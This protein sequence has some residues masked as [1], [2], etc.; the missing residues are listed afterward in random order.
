MTTVEAEKMMALLFCITRYQKAYRWRW[1][2]YPF[3]PRNPSQLKAANAACKETEK[4]LQE[5]CK[6]FE[7]KTQLRDVL[8]ETLEFLA[9]CSSLDAAKAVVLLYT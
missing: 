1:A 8:H 7:S 9:P 5:A 2:P 6:V 4:K 3:G